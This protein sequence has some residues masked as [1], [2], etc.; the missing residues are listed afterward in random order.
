[1]EILEE[2]WSPDELYTRVTFRERSERKRCITLT[3][4]CTC[5]HH[6]PRARISFRRSVCCICSSSP[7]FH[8]P[9]T[10]RVAD[11]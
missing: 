6:I 9:S 3:R 7:T 10:P 4:V 8:A 5:P 2:D 11:S 1:M